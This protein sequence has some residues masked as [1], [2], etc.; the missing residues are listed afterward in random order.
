MFMYAIVLAAEQGIDLSPLTA[1]LPKHLLLIGNSSCLV[2]A[3]E[4]MSDAGSIGS[5]SPS[6]PS[7][8]LLQRVPKVIAHSNRGGIQ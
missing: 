7:G 8:Q 2:Y 6:Y 4:A 1:Q 3:I 5:P